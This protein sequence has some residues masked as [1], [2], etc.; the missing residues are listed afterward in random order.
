MGATTATRQDGAVSAVPTG[1]ALGAEVCGIDLGHVTDA[2]FDAIHRAWLAHSVLLFRG[3]SLSDDDLVAF[4]RRCGDLGWAP[5]QE[6]GRR[7]V[8]GKPEISIVSNV[9]G[10]DGQAIGSLGAGEAVWHTDM[11]YLERP[12]EASMLYALEVPPAGGDTH[13]CSMYAAY[14]EL[15][16]ALKQRI[17]GL[18]VKHDG[19]YNSGGFLRAGVTPTDGP[20]TSPCRL[21]PLVCRHPE[22]GRRRCST[23][24]AAGTPTST[25]CRSRS[26]KRCWTS[27]GDTRPGR[28]SPGRTGGGRAT[29]CCGTTAAP[30][31][32]ATPSTPRRAASCTAPGSRARRPPQP[33]RA[34]RPGLRPCRSGWPVEDV[35][36]A[37]SHP[38][39]K[40]GFRPPRGHAD[41]RQTAGTVRSAPARG[42]APGKG[43]AF[44]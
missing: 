38:A 12:P 30:C 26:P 16:E 17:A 8:E 4:S 44:P 9:L 27:C 5:A 20:R 19:T 37:A 36:G 28:R 11:S 3:Q 15:P 25:A 29:W 42:S 10:P 23:W 40:A 7:F 35:A 39:S 21:H 13:F 2:Q 41:D 31:T 24:A 33:E 22:T 6:N 14:E 43:N 34:R 32:G 18:R 1:A